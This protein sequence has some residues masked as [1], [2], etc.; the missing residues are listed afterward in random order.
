MNVLFF[1]DI[2]N[3]IKWLNEIIEKS[4]NVDLIVCLGDL[5]DM[6]KNYDL[7]LEKLNNIKKK[8]LIISGNNE[9]PNMMHESIEK[10][11]NI[12]S[13]EEKK[14]IDVTSFLGIGGSTISPFN[15]PYELS[16]E[17]YEKKLLK[18]KYVDVLVTHCP[19]K[20]TKLDKIKSG[21]HIGSTSI[22]KWIELNQPKYCACGHVHERIGIKEKIGRTLCFNPGH[23][24]MII[25]L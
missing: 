24:G 1:S 12:I 4:K 13:I 8:I 2:H 7:F 10:Y 25:K 23:K 6:G 16:E 22:R 5:S 11:E 9:T 19:P 15:T 20:N 17:E 18:F 3:N 14:Y 21:L